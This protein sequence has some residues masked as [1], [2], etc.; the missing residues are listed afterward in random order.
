MGNKK[1]FTAFQIQHTLNSLL[2]E[3]FSYKLEESEMEI[4]LG[5]LAAAIETM[6]LK[7]GKQKQ[8]T[9]KKYTLS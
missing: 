6:N 5:A 7:T 3:S 9:M 1:D 4:G 2:K 8:F